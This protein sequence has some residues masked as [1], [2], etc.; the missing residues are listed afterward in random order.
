LSDRDI[1]HRTKIRQ[2]IM[3]RAE[4]A[5]ARVRNRLAMVPGKVSFTFDSWTSDPGDPFLSVTAHYIITAP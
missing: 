2:E 3:S 1:P 5:E 4:T